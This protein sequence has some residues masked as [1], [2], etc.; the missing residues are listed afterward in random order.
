MILHAGDRIASQGLSGCSM[1]VSALPYSGPI[2][3]FSKLGIVKWLY[4][5]WREMMTLRAEDRKVGQGSSGCSSTKYRHPHTLAS[6]S[7][8]LEATGHGP[9]S[10]LPTAP[11]K[12][13]HCEGC[14]AS[15]AL[16]ILY[17]T[18][19]PTHNLRHSRN[20]TLAP[21]VPQITQDGLQVVPGAVIAVRVFGR[22]SGSHL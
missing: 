18:K 7:A 15:V 22:G 2:L 5:H 10:I 4:D 16:T 6:H 12:S 13:L 3:E 8:R 1:S 21:E 20:V 11:C 14:K 9:P 19:L 17:A